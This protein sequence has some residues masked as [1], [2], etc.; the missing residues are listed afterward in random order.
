MGG[1]EKRRKFSAQAGFPPAPH[2][3]AVYKTACRNQRPEAPRMSRAVISA[4]RIR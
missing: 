4:P 2:P 1:S 3:P